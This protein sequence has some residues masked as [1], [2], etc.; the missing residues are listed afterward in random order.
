[1]DHETKPD[2][3]LD[4]ADDLSR[5][6]DIA[7]ESP[8]GMDGALLDGR[9]RLGALIGSGGMAAVY[10]GRDEV[11][12]RDVAVKLFLPVSDSGRGE[13]T[14][15]IR[16][17]ARTLAG[18]NHRNLVTV[19]DAGVD[20]D[21]RSS[22]GTNARGRSYLVMELVGGTDLRRSHR[23]TSTGEQLAYTT[24]HTAVIGAGT[25]RALAYIHDHGIIH[26]DVKPAN[27]LPGDSTSGPSQPKLTD[28]GIA[29]IAPHRHPGREQIV[30]TAAYLSPEQARGEEVTAATDVYSLGL[31]LLEC[32]TG[33]IVFPGAP[34]V[35][36]AARLYRKPV[37]PASLS[38]QWIDL[39]DTMTATEP[40]SRPTAAEVAAT[41]ESLQTPIKNNT[42][43][44]TSATTRELPTFT[45][46][47]GAAAEAT[48]PMSAAPSTPLV[49]GT[50][51]QRL[52]A[53]SGLQLP[54][55]KDDRKSVSGRAT[56]IPHRRSRA[57]GWI[58]A[59]V[60]AAL[61][62]IAVAV[63]LLLTVPVDSGSTPVDYPPVPGQLGESLNE[64][65]QSVS[66]P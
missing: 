37:I 43:G 16:S 8:A 50:T 35:S 19:F 61:I 6:T 29:G 45:V 36:A 63:A 33:D 13:E 66:N 49:R 2:P 24:A 14:A 30:G 17:E 28:F 3:R 15:T 4:L 59:V 31:V 52:S 11:L 54:E 10:Q 41:L 48:S 7:G 42:S 18:L 40:A 56:P 64:L 5:P 44:S 65:Q 27:I 22:D 23:R 38:Y 58:V 1:M 53:S 39:L 25:A 34:M 57:N 32:I 21:H 62:A 12:T 51:G 46:P 26:R 55:D 47:A 60:I 20:T 9:Y